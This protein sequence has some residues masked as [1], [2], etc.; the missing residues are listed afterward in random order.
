MDVMSVAVAIK[1]IGA[2]AVQAALDSLGKA[3]SNA[4]GK[5][6]TTDKATQDLTNS[7]RTLAGAVGAAFSA[8]QIGA[9]L[10]SYT[11]LTN[12]LKLASTGAEGLAAAQAEVYRI[13]Q[14][15]R[16]PINDVA[17]LYAKTAQSAEALG[18][19]ATDAAK[20]TEFVGKSLAISGTSA[21]AARGALIQLS[22]AL[23]AG[24]VRAEEFN[25]VQEGAPALIRAVEKTLGLQSGGLRKLAIEGRLSS[26]VFAKAMLAN[27]TV[28]KSFADFMPTMAQQ[29]T[30]LRNDFILLAGEIDKSAQ[31]TGTFARLM[32]FLRDNLPDVVGLIGAAAA[33]WIAYQAAAASAAAVTAVLGSAGTI[34]ALVALA[35]GIKTVADSIAF[36]QIA[37]GAAGGPLKV[38][39]TVA[40]LAAGVLAYKVIS[41][42]VQKGIDGMAASIKKNTGATQQGTTAAADYGK[43]LQALLAKSQ[44]VAK[45]K[46]PSALEKMMAAEEAQARRLAPWLQTLKEIRAELQASEGPRT[47]LPTIGRDLE[48]LLARTKTAG[49]E[50]ARTV[51]GTVTAFQVASFDGIELGISQA[52]AGLD[53]KRD[54]MIAAYERNVLEPA[55]QMGDQFAQILSAGIGNAFQALA[56]KGGNIGDFFKSFGQTFLAGLGDMLIQA[57]TKGL[58]AAIA[59]NTMLQALFTPA[60]IAASLAVIALGGTLKGVASR[61]VTTGQGAPVTAGGFGYTGMGGGGGITLPGV[62]YLPTAAGGMGSRVMAANPVNVTIIGPNDP[63]AQRQMQELIQN[64]N[65]RGQTRAV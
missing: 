22:Q 13:A 32:G 48:A 15:T 36:A 46:E 29:L 11:N 39:A 25:S 63:T 10:D 65:R 9:A 57:G 41:A 24:T 62:T 8:Q 54:E 61:M 38:A 34:S 30:T 14:L 2:K 19:S 42:Q 60:G 33:G 49:A 4:S 56:A 52:I 20:I 17:V 21:D 12:Q 16:Q 28:A 6:Q 26:E 45:T 44:P 27:T 64:A 7:F 47:V 35:R 51:A 50:V 37:L 55:R 59:V 1:E 3:A 40:A 23:A 53:A 5:L 31:V 43:E 58:A 18:L